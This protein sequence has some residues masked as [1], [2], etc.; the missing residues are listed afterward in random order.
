MRA[1]RQ[2]DRKAIASFQ[3]GR[4]E[5]QEGPAGPVPQRELPQKEEEEEDMAETVEVR[6]AGAAGAR[7]Y[8]AR[9][10]KPTGQAV[11]QSHLPIPHTVCGS[12]APS[13]LTVCRRGV[14]RQRQEDSHKFKGS[15]SY[16]AVLSQ[17]TKE[18]L[19]Q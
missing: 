15:L 10:Q 8:A 1:K 11:V 6:T 3:H 4:Q 9:S 16:R 5:K 12:G 14:R 13:R 7:G 19:Q 17:I 18:L 2:R